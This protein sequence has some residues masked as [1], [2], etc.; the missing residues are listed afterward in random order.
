MVKSNVR[1]MAKPRRRT[2]VVTPELMEEFE[3]LK[4]EIAEE[5]IKTAEALARAEETQ[6]W[7]RSIIESY[8]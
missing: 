7:L 6:R 3:A 1:A 5:K 4:R 8:R 2:I